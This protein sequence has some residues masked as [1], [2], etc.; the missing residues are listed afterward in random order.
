[1]QVVSQHFLF[2]SSPDASIYKTSWQSAAELEARRVRF[3]TWFPYAKVGVAELDPPT[4]PLLCGPR[5]WSTG[6]QL[7]PVTLSCPSSTI[8]A[9][10]FASWGT[11]SGVCGN[12]TADPACNDPGS[13][14]TATAACVGQSSCVLS[15]S[16]FKTAGGC[17]GAQAP[18]LAVQVRCADPS[19]RHSYWNTSLLDSFFGDLWTSVN[20]SVGLR[21]SNGGV[22]PAGGVPGGIPI[23]SFSTAPTWLYSP[24]EWRYEDDPL[25]PDYSYNRGTAPAANLSQLGAYYGRLYSWYALGGFSD[26]Y[27]V[28][29]DGGYHYD[30]DY[31]EVG[32][33][34]DYE[35][36]HTAV[37][38][39]LE[40]DAIV[41]GLRDAGVDT[42][43][44]PIRYNGLNLPN[45]DDTSK[46]VEWATYFLNGS[47][48]QPGV[49]DAHA[50]AS[51]GYHAYPTQGG[52]TSDPSTLAAFFDYVDELFIPK[53][54]AVDTVIAALSPHTR[55][56]LDE[57]GV[58]S[59]GALLPGLPPPA[60]GPRFWV[61]SGSYF[62]FLLARVNALPSHSV[63][64]IGHSQLM[65]APGQEPSVTLLDWSSG[66]G[67]AAYWATWVSVRAWT[68]GDALLPS[69]S[70]NET[71]VHALGWWHTPASGGRPDLPGASTGVS[72][73]PRVL[74][75]NR[76]N[77]WANASVAPPADGMRCTAW[78]V[79]ERNGLEPPAQVDCTPAPGAGPQVTL[80][81]WPYASAV[82]EFAPVTGSTDM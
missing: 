31:V 56:V 30:I 9:V 16:M 37:S 21:A 81:L 23:P 19:L 82:L 2:A 54:Q 52:I 63:V 20:G 45:I 79:D 65:D 47:N 5:A 74:L 69:S 50:S 58:D 42:P 17:G 10:D 32:N 77:A 72:R 35:H 76:R 4:G 15:P 14:A 67:T 36:G 18:Y 40:F 64:Q 51:I 3:A 48:H 28:R 57:C 80:E 61:A 75:I 13:L 38:Y 29:H 33:E 44:W 62:L 73:A 68:L 26:E 71:A 41:S 1:M 25:A 39:T 34:V 49:W 43:Q 60:N 46:V 53:V 55:T 22:L 70:S 8:L 11:P 27:G 59:D 7:N 12:Y 78:L 66:R 6:G 24:L